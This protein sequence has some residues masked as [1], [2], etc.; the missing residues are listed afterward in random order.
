MRHPVSGARSSD[1]RGATAT[2][3]ALLV[4][5]IALFIFAS[6]AAVAT[7]LAGLYD[8][9]CDEVAGVAGNSNC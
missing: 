9:S 3:Y 1:E 7:N 4:S 8:R 5:L 2:E 6:V